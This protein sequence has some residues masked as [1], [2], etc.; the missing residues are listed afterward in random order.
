MILSKEFGTLRTLILGEG[1]SPL[2]PSKW[3]TERKLKAVY[4]MLIRKL[5]RSAYEEAEALYTGKVKD[6]EDLLEV[7]RE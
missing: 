3:E 4:G 1:N 5:Q 6:L 7:E 2:S